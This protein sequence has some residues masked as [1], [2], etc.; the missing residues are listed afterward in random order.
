MPRG[1]YTIIRARPAPRAAPREPDD[2]SA[3]I[4]A[5][6]V[7]QKPIRS[8][9][10]VLQFQRYARTLRWLLRDLR[11]EFGR[12]WLIAVVAG[13]AGVLIQG[14]TIGLVIVFAQRLQSDAVL[15]GFGRELP[16]RSPEA[17]MIVAVIVL[18]ALAFSAFLIFLQNRLVI[19][20]GYRYEDVC[21]ERVFLSLGFRPRR[22]GAQAP[23]LSADAEIMRLGSGDAGQVNR[24][25]R[26]LMLTPVSVLTFVAAT[27]VMFRVSLLLSLLI[28]PIIGIALVVIYRLNI[29]AA[30]ASLRFER[31]NPDAR[32]QVRLAFQLL[33]ETH[34]RIERNTDFIRELLR[35][36]SAQR[37]RDANLERILAPMRAMLVANILLASCLAL[38]LLYFGLRVLEGSPGQWQYLV[39]YIAALTYS[40]NSLKTIATQFT[41]LNRFYPNVRRVHEFLSAVEQGDAAAV[42][43]FSVLPSGVPGISGLESLEAGPG[44][45]IG[46]VT[47]EQVNRYTFPDIVSSLASSASCSAESVL[48]SSSLLVRSSSSLGAQAPAIRE[49]H[50]RALW[51]DLGTA[52][53]LKAQLDD[54]E[55]WNW[56]AGE[57]PALMTGTV[58]VSELTIPGETARF[59]ITAA[60]VLRSG[61]PFVFIDENAVRMLPDDWRWRFIEHLRGRGLFLVYAPGWRGIAQYGENAVA[62]LAGGRL[63]IVLNPRDATDQRALIERIVNEDRREAPVEDVEQLDE[64]AA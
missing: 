10:V 34:R 11:G 63:V 21:Q 64:E 62:V 51:Q 29:R 5:P 8:H 60:A 39:A 37:V 50:Q 40:L 36:G 53:D 27:A 17:L 55:I 38:I 28:L 47:A 56:L 4:Q 43:E 31:D 58:Q 46:L 12:D 61:K 6:L 15:S 48:A 13:S 57:V 33:K 59:V 32:R 9:P 45:I 30:A 24:A 19:Q 22:A 7:I 49:S 44:R 1:A 52:A 16:S 3:S 18:L 41:S 20:T 54:P 26:L 42:S 14:S 23:E 35:G 2:T 25:V